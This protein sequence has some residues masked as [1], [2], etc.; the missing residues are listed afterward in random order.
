MFKKSGELNKA[1]KGVTLLIGKDSFL[2][3]SCPTTNKSSSKVI[4]V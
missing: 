4:P 1:G 2:D 3:D